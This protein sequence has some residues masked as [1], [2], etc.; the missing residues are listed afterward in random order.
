MGSPA[1]RQ[2]GGPRTHLAWSTPPPREPCLPPEPPPAHLDR[3][4]GHPEVGADADGQEQVEDG[5]LDPE[6]KGGGIGRVRGG[7]RPRALRFR[8]SAAHL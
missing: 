5:G 3:R 1:S 8:C 7:P 4:V 2:A 6:G